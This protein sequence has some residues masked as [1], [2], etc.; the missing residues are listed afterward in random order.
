VFG[1][2]SSFDDFGSEFDKDRLP[3]K[4][5]EGDPDVNDPTDN[6]PEKKRPP[7]PKRDRPG[8]PP[9]PRKQTPANGRTRGTY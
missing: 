6:N 7:Q 2:T 1:S 8:K 9:K 4:K 5:P 3:D